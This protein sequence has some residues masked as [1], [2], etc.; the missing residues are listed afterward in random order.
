M[1]DGVWTQPRPLAG[2][3]LSSS[4]VKAPR[5]TRGRDSTVPPTPK[6]LPHA[7]PLHP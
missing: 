5:L 6:A 2:V 4:D 7:A 1:P 3:A